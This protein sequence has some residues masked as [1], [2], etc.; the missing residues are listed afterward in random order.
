MEYSTEIPFCLGVIGPHG[1][2]GTYTG[3]DTQP[4]YFWRKG[5]LGFFL[6]GIFNYGPEGSGSSN[7]PLI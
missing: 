1:P 7:F 5:M 3:S 6:S 2:Y 4:I